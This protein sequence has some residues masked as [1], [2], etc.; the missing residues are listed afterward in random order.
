MTKSKNKNLDELWAMATPRHFENV[1]VFLKSHNIPSVN[2][3]TPWSV[4]WLLN[5]GADWDTPL[6][7]ESSQTKCMCS[8]VKGQICTPITKWSCMISGTFMWLLIW[9][10]RPEAEAHCQRRNVHTC[11]RGAIPGPEHHWLWCMVLSVVLDVVVLLCAGPLCYHNTDR[12]ES[13]LGL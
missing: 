2:E 13:I 6:A 8:D 3:L 4:S 5:H 10:K 9:L 1:E 12:D 11:V 7:F